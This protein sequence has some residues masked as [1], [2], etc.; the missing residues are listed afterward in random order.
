[1]KMKQLCIVLAAVSTPGLSTA[2][3]TLPANSGP[4]ITASLEIDSGGALT[5]G[6]IVD[7]AQSARVLVSTYDSWL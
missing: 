2:Q 1:M 6:T 5:M 7:S 4:K 3:P